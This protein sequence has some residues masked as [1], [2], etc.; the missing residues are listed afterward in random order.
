MKP[1]YRI[2]NAADDPTVAN[3]HIIDFIGDWMDEAMNRAYNETITVTAAA[4]VDALSKLP[5][6][7]K[8]VR[9][10]I[11]SPGGDVF[12]ALNIANALRDQQSTKGRVVET[13]VDGLAASAASIIA[14]AGSKVVMADNALMMVHNPLSIAIGNAAEL[15]QAADVLDTV[16]DT[17]VA[18]Y[19]WHSKKT[20]AELVALLDG[21]TWMTADEAIANGLATEKVAGLSAAASIDRR[22]AARLKVPEQ[23][24]DRVNNWV[25]PEA[26]KPAAAAAADVLRL[27]REGECAMNVAE[28]LL[29]AGATLDQVKAK[30][31]SDKAARAAATA[32]ASQITT[33]CTNAKLPELAA[34][35]IKAGMSVDDV[36]ATLVTL[37]AKLDKV[38]IDGGLTPDNSNRQ[39]SVNVVEIYIKRNGGGN[40]SKEK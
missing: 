15:R 33:L 18:T 21:E 6:A 31:D 39:T 27:C 7:V 9:V 2:Q 35:Y 23:F 30:V 10:H 8:T 36:K 4:F 19:Q 25:V 3:I 22:A 1:W 11:N 37:T 40:S 16:R 20:S 32:R 29:A 34:T 24:R 12:S 17:L 14:M 38:E 5:A 26:L 13:I 28:D